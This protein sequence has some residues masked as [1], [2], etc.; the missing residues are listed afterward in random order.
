MWLTVIKW[1][2]KKKKWKEKGKEEKYDTFKDSCLYT[3]MS[4]ILCLVYIF[5]VS[6]KTGLEK[7]GM[8]WSKWWIS[9]WKN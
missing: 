2:E 6:M 9:E 3:F 4:F 5:V 7:N 8:W 1:L